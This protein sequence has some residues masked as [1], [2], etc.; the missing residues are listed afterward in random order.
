MAKIEAE[1]EVSI[2][3]LIERVLS[4]ESGEFSYFTENEVSKA[5]VTDKYQYEVSYE[6]IEEKKVNIIVNLKDKYIEPIET[7]AWN[8]GIDSDPES[9]LKIEL[10]KFSVECEVE[11]V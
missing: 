4:L 7:D 11:R 6:T 5:I 9:A 10:N 2:E 3:Q 1:I 8:L